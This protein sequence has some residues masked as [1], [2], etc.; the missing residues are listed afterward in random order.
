VTVVVVQLNNVFLEIPH[1]E[2]DNALV[3]VNN[4]DKVLDEI[5]RVGNTLGNRINLFG[6]ENAFD[7]H[8]LEFCVALIVTG[9]F[10][11]V[12]SLGLNLSFKNLLIIITSGT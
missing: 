5:N 4:L 8:P 7:V 6:G 10:D 12:H 1:L 3:N 11:F 9:L 2:W